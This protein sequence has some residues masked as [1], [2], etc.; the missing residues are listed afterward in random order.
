[1]SQPDMLSDQSPNFK[2]PAG[3]RAGPR[4][5]EGEVLLMDGKSAEKP[6]RA[7]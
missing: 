7:R 1:M 6:M 2:E 5:G 4:V 3:Q